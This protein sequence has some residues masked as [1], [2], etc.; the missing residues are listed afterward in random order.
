MKWIAFFLVFLVGTAQA[1]S[2][3][4]FLLEKKGILPSGMR[5]E[6]KVQEAPYAPSLQLP[7]DDC[8]MWGVDCGNPKFSINMLSL[9]LNDKK[10]HW[11]HKYVADLSYVRK[12]EIK[13]AKAGVKLL[14]H[15]GDAAGSYSAEFLIKKNRLVE[16]IVRHGEFP[17]E[18]WEKTLVC[19]DLLDQPERY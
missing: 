13:E 7:E 8:G 10:V 17:D 2:D 16:R 18:V 15:G 1:S 3:T 19:N 4:P 12:V 6:I 14:I 9:K 11:P 5:Y